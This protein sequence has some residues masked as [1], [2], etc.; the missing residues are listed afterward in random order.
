MGEVVERHLGEGHDRVEDLTVVLP[1]SAD[2]TDRTSQETLSVQVQS[3]E[4]RPLSLPKQK[5]KL[6]S[7]VKFITKKKRRK[8]ENAFDDLFKG[9]P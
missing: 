7:P 3:K 8:V 9:T 5:R 6:T 1:S 2:N 4:E